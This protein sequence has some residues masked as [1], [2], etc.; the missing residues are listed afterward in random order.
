MPEPWLERTKF[1][2]DL[3]DSKRQENWKVEQETPMVPLM[4]G[5]FAS[6]VTML[7]LEKFDEFQRGMRF[8][9]FLKSQDCSSV[10]GRR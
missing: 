6:H 7:N 4:C 2:Q 3:V 8:F 1:A 9:A 10:H 5:I